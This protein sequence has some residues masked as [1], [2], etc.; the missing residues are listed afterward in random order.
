MSKASFQPLTIGKYLSKDEFRLV[1]RAREFAT[2][3]HAGQKRISGEPFIE[4]PLVVA[5]ILSDFRLDATTLSAALLHDVVEDTPTTLAEVYD[6]FGPEITSLVDGLTKTTFCNLQNIPNSAQIQDSQA[7]NLAKLTQAILK[8][9]RVVLIR[10]ADRLHNMRTLSALPQAKQKRIAFDTL[11]TY[12]P[13]ASCF[14]TTT[15]RNELHQ[16]ALPYLESSQQQFS[17]VASD[18]LIKHYTPLWIHAS[19]VWRSKSSAKGICF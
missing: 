8:D 12:V 13:L 18:D 2:V 5:Q 6:H 14:C 3:A 10:L 4:H 9:S 15:I 7:A 19:R 11:I 17:D 1:S 16:L